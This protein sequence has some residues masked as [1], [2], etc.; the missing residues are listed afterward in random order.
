MPTAFCRGRRHI[1]LY[2]YGFIK[3]VGI[4]LA[5]G[6]YFVCLRLF[7]KAVG[8]RMA[9]GN[10]VVCLR[11]F[12]KAVGICLAVGIQ[13]C[14]RYQADGATYTPTATLFRPSAYNFFSQ[15]NNL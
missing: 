10:Y 1:W 3:A 7:R 5:V 14:I 4:R 9:V 8:I 15:I 12:K 13:V 6:I 2:A 11:L